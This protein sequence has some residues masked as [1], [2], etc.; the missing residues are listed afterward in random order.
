MT[1][2][3]EFENEVRKTKT[4]AHVLFETS[5]QY[6]IAWLEA[7]IKALHQPNVISSEL[8]L[9]NYIPYNSWREECKNCGDTRDRK[10]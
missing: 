8:C 5:N 9:H 10:F 1:L 2:R 3:E 7:K 6:Y 4:L